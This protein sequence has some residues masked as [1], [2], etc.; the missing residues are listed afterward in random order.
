VI[1]K[2]PMNADKYRCWK[3]N[4]MWVVRHPVDHARGVAYHQA[5]NCWTD[6]ILHIRAHLRMDALGVPRG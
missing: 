2:D 5:F 3:W 4:T 1:H 6:A